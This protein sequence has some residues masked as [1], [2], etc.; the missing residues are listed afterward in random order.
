MGSFY[1]LKCKN[2]HLKFTKKCLNIRVLVFD[3]FEA[4]RYYFFFS[5]ISGCHSNFLKIEPEE[6]LASLFSKFSNSKKKTLKPIFYPFSHCLWVIP[7]IRIIRYP[8]VFL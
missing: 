5:N 7:D 8:L 2:N 1:T 3:R 6:R 4:S